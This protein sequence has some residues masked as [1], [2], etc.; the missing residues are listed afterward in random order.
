[1]V[2]VIQV[3]IKKTIQAFWK[4]G[5]YDRFA[6]KLFQKLLSSMRIAD[7]SPA[8]LAAIKKMR[9]DWFILDYDPLSDRWKK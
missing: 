3:T 1:M 4:Q 2:T 6:T 7:L 9:Y 5:N 8:T